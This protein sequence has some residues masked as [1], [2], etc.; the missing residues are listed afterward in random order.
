MTPPP[1]VSIIIPCHNAARWLAAT[2]DSAFEQTWPNIE[3][4]LVDDGSTDR[5][6]EIARAYEPRGLRLVTRTTPGGAATARN[7]GL[8]A[9]RG[10][11]LQFLDADD[12]L[13]PD[14]ISRQLD[15]LIPAGPD[16]VGTAA[17]ARFH[18][19][20]SEARFD[21]E[22][23]WVDLTPA[24]WL[25]TSWRDHRMMATAAWL[26]P[27]SLADAVGPWNTALHPNPVDDMEYFSRVLLASQ[28]VLFC[29]EARA[30]YRSGVPGSLSR[31][32]SDAAWH[33]I[34]HSFLLTTDRLLAKENSARTR[35]AAA[36]AL[37]RLVYESYP[38]VPALRRLAAT[39]IAELG[40]TDIR[41]DAGPR[42]RAVQALLG[43]RLTK[44]LHD[45]VSPRR[46]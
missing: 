13:A 25:V 40:G 7:V 21:P 18:E 12:L 8:A 6:V 9:A 11:Y 34:Y 33:S 32:R 16:A 19:V 30:Y 23:L 27:R 17:W 22:S 35:A 29:G 36:A 14:K 2:L 39:R 20:P 5:S 45:L 38:R 4:L 41:P 15:R 31:Q 28:L 44:R 3:V 10:D 24:D 42:R 37:Q 26:V 43:W 1:L 46:S